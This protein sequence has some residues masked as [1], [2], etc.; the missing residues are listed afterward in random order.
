MQP[1]SPSNPTS[2]HKGALNVQALQGVSRPPGDLTPGIIR[3]PFRTLARGPHPGHIP[4]F[5]PSRGSPRAFFFSLAWGPHPWHNPHVLSPQPPSSNIVVVKGVA[6]GFQQLLKSP[7]EPKCSETTTCI[8]FLSN[9]SLIPFPIVRAPP[10]RAR[11]RLP[12]SPRRP[13]LHRRH[14]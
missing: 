11:R 5:L 6:V 7:L 3:S 14:S 13:S 10:L 9:I 1:H 12:G 8:R 2:P 4:S